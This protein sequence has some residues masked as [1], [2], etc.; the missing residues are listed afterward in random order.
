MRKTLTFL[1][2]VTAVIL[3]ASCGPSGNSFRIKGNFR[4]MKAGELYLYSLNDNNASYDT[5][6]VRDGAFSY[7]GVAS[8]ATPYVLVFPNGMEQ[9]IFVDKGLDVKYEA[10]ANDLKNYS[11]DGGEENELM[12]KF[13]Q[14]TY[15]LNP[16]QVMATARTYIDEHAQSPVALYLFDQYFLHNDN[17]SLKEL[18]QMLS[19][20]K[21]SNPD[22]RHLL[23]IE[24][25]ISFV[26][27]CTV[28]KKMADA[29]LTKRDKTTAKL[30]AKGKDKDYTLIAFW[31]TW[32]QNGYDVVWQLR[33]LSDN[34][35]EDDNLRI[36]GISL[37]L[38]RFRWED[39]TRQD[40]ASATIEHYYDGLAFESPVVQSYGIT[41][42]PT[43][44]L[45]DRSH[46]ILCISKSVE[47]MKSDVAKHVKTNNKK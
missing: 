41:T 32:K 8:K 42:V 6:T 36:V 12:N 17:V 20:L 24:S 37:D 3:I 19:K 26:K 14:E 33:Q 39:A 2:L 44:V 1:S 23:D 25:R 21:K 29:K 47:D 30:W 35:K 22:N 15:T 45:T 34:H 5:L 38:E 10:T 43:F 46:K 31:S 7:K 11:V 28:G 27:R 40:T 4:D 13:R 16:T 9:V 18:Q